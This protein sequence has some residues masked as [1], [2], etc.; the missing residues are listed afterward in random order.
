MHKSS[1][2]DDQFQENSKYVIVDYIV[3][4]NFDLTHIEVKYKYKLCHSI[5]Q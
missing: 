1:S 3:I 5:M 4:N 2:F